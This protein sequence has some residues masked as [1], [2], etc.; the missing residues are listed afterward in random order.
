MLFAHVLDAEVIDNEEELDGVT[1]VAPEARSGGGFVVACS[2]EA[3]P[4]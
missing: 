4:R 2:V 3:L 1:C